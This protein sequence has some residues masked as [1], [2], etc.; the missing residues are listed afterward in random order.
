MI[1]KFALP[2]LA[3]ALMLC[4]CSSTPEPTAI[5]VVA[6]T[7]QCPAFPTQPRELM[8]PPEKVDYLSPDG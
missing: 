2:M 8:K 4:A 3:A 6:E 1:T 7:R 5:T